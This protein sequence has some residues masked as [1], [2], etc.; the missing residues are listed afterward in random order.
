[1]PRCLV[2]RTFPEGLTIPPHCGGSR[3]LP[4]GGQQQCRRHPSPGRIPNVTQDKRKT[5]CSYDASSPEAIQLA[6][7]TTCW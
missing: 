7:A 5:F 6:A 2:E 3:D 4:C 1:M